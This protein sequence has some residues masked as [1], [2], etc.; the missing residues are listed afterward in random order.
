MNA[1]SRVSLCATLL[2]VSQPVAAQTATPVSPD[3]PRF[4]QRVRIVARSDRPIAGRAS[5]T[6]LFLTADSIAF[7]A[8]SVQ[9]I[10]SAADSTRT[11]RI[12]CAACVEVHYALVD[13][14]TVE[15]ATPPAADH[16]KRTRRRGVIWGALIGGAA[17]AGVQATRAGGDGVAGAA[18]PGLLLGAWLGGT[19]GAGW[20]QRPAWR[21]VYRAPP[22]R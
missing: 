22:A 3:V 21:V 8:D 10:A 5:G 6:L 17:F 12:P 14:A 18:V 13:L 4:G 7:K 1:R 16:W 2:V 9:S 15:V 20:P 19:I 11:V